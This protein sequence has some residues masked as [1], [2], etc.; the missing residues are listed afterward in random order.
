MQR[1]EPGFPHK[2][3]FYKGAMPPCSYDPYL[4]ITG[5]PPEPAVRS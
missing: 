1:A 5:G 3:G 4:K 2:W